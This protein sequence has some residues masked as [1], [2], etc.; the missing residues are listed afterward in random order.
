MPVGK[1]KGQL[2]RNFDKGIDW[3]MQRFSHAKAGQLRGEI[4]PVYL[5]D[6]DAPQAIREQFPQARLLV[7]LRNPVDR[8]YSFYKLHRGN[9]IIPEMS[10]E[11]ALERENVYVD[12]GMYGAHMERYL[13]SFDR[14]QILILIFEELIARPEDQLNQVFDFLEVSRPANLDPSKYHTNE[15]AKRRSNT[16]HKFAFKT[17]QW[18]VEHNMSR[19]LELARAAG[20][21]SLFN[22]INAAPANKE[23]LRSDT[24]AQL[25]ETFRDDIQR[26]ENLFDL[27]LAAWQ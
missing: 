17:S 22:K 11:E 15:S 5:S 21:H 1:L 4:S 14:S 9:S 26:L 16:L 2:N 3:Y 25:A 12:T 19:L 7:C 13:A 10:F 18:L 8:A 24:R 27:N 23:K 6:P 20:A